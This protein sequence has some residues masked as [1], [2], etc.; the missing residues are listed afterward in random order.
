ML[1]VGR[2]QPER[3][4]L[5]EIK[6]LFEREEIAATEAARRIVDVTRS[7]G[8]RRDGAGGSAGQGDQAALE[9]EPPATKEPIEEGDVGVVCW[10]AVL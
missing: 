10:M 7:Y 5:G 4:A 2:S 1:Q 6:R 3:K 9:V 8:L